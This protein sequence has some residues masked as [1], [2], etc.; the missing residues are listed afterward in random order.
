[1]KS[2]PCVR[3]QLGACTL[4]FHQVL[5]EISWV[6][7]NRQLRARIALLVLVAA[8]VLGC[9]HGFSC[10]TLDCDRFNRHIMLQLVE[11]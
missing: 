10:A 9:G 11:R 8:F 1:M 5:L 2:P 3:L 7:L 4:A 6:T